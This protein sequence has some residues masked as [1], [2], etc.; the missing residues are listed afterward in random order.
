MLPTW[1]ARSVECKLLTSELL[2]LIEIAKLRRPSM[3][4]LSAA[5]GISERQVQR[6]LRKLEAAGYISREFTRPRR[7]RYE[8][9]RDEAIAETPDIPLG[10]LMRTL[11]PGSSSW[12]R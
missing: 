6:A 8:L 2:V 5:V 7:V 11:A 9:R 12:S 10:S 1:D 4:E 3:P